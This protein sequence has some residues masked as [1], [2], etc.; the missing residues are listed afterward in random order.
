MQF[1]EKTLR[2]ANEPIVSFPLLVTFHA[3][4]AQDAEEMSH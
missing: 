2:M 1:P 3:D 4:W